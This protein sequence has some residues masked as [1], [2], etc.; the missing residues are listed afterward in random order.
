MATMHRGVHDR[1][2]SLGLAIVKLTAVS[3]GV[4]ALAGMTL[5]QVVDIASCR[6][7]LPRI[8]RWK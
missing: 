2:F 4:A 1:V 5:L 3:L 7:V 6:F 8:G